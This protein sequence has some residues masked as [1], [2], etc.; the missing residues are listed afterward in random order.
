MVRGALFVLLM[1]GAAMDDDPEVAKWVARLGN[2]A[3]PAD[4]E[5]M[6]RLIAIG[7]KSI[8][9]C[10]TLLLDRKETALRRMRAAM[11]LGSVRARTAVRDL[12]ACVPDPHWWVASSSATAL[13]QIG[14][15]S[16]LPD[17][18]RLLGTAEHATVRAAIEESIEQL[19]S[20]DFPDFGWIAWAR[21]IEEARVRA[22]RENRI[23][24]AFVTP[25]DWW[26]HESGYE[27]AEK[28]HKAGVPYEGDAERLR[29]TEPGAVKE[30]AILTALLCHPEL[31]A[32][33]ADRFVPV[34][35]HMHAWHFRYRTSMGWADP[36]TRLGTTARE[37]RPPAL[38]FASPDG[39]LLHQVVRMGTFSP[40]LTYRTCLAVLA[41]NP[42]Y[43]AAAKVPTGAGFQAAVERL[44]RGGN[45][46]SAREHL[47]TAPRR[48]RNWAALARA[49]ML[50]L[51][52]DLESAEKALLA[53]RPRTALQSALLGEVYLLT[54][55]AEE[56][57]D[58][59]AATKAPEGD[60][61]HRIRSGLALAEERIG[62]R[63]RARELWEGVAERAGSGPWATR[64]KLQLD[65]N[66]PFPRE[67]ETYRHLDVDALTPTTERGGQKTPIRAAVSYLL[68]QQQPDGSWAN[69]HNRQGLV[70]RDGRPLGE[71]VPR[72]ALCVSALRAVR[73]GLHP[74]L[75]DRAE[76]AI[77]KGIR[78]V[79]AWSEDP[80]RKVWQL[81]Y[82]LHLELSLLKRI[83]TALENRHHVAATHP[84]GAD[85]ADP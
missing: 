43:A 64:A 29:R 72:T 50:L 75:S 8:P 51:E 70:S 45:F 12:L 11:V 18:K 35:V 61:R 65:R 20:C 55:R 47:R 40:H 71:I 59:L 78:F 32:L 1:L 17:L 26:H 7:D 23:V 68:S 60:L 14:D 52:G 10:R 54:D 42:R 27:G 9:P 13:G 76:A 79:T 3:N 16:A 48:L 31:A 25:W 66:G 85:A 49:R 62:H 15:P 33:V 39:A 80:E 24:L 28:V 77:R 44:I 63:D 82:A 57:R 46:Q 4:V 2:P 21:T 37:A 73:G 22:A 38:V 83:Q 56:A 5:P 67:W 34:R 36:L 19:R 53:I 41:R 30:R 69:A 58:L 6:R 81:T 74:R 84:A